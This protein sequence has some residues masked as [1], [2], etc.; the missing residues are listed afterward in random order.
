MYLLNFLKEFSNAYMIVSIFE[1]IYT[2]KS[3]P[4]VL[5]GFFWHIF[6]M[7]KTFPDFFLKKMFLSIS[8]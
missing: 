1:K 4:G 7:N 2:I 5:G 8:F 3:V 6:T